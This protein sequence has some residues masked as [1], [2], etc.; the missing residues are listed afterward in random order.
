MWR[1][2]TII[3]LP[4]LENTHTLQSLPDKYEVSMFEL[5]NTFLGKPALRAGFS[6]GT[7]E[8][9]NIKL[10]LS[11]LCIMAEDAGPDSSAYSVFHYSPP[12]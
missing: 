10:F 12:D 8:T 4:N 1:E 2:Q 3:L 11:A 6:Q 9:S 5:H 7:R